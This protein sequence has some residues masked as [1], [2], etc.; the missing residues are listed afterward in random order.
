MFGP[1]ANTLDGFE[2]VDGVECVR[3]KTRTAG[4]LKMNLGEGGAEEVRLVRK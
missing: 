3:V 2:T 1:D 4:T